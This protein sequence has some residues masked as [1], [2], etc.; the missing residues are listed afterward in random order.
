MRKGMEIRLRKTLFL[1]W[2]IWLRKMQIIIRLV[3]CWRRCL[4]NI[5][6][7]LCTLMSLWYWRQKWLVSFLFAFTTVFISIFH[8]SRISW[9]WEKIII[10]IYNH[11][12]P[13][14]KVW[15]SSHIHTRFWCLPSRRKWW[16]KYQ[17]F[18]KSQL[19]LKPPK[20]P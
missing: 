8:V 5:A 14:K 6:T 2:I 20:R 19:K 17:I 4:R 16:I 1:G 12:K 15:F 18:M 10:I 13:S 11:R 7:N 9:F 3:G